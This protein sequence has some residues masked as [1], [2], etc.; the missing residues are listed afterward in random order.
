MTA[1]GGKDSRE[2]AQINTIGDHFRA[3]INVAGDESTLQAVREINVIEQQ[4]E[5]ITSL[6]T[7]YLKADSLEDK[8]PAVAKTKWLDTQAD[9]EHL[10]A[11]PRRRAERTDVAQVMDKLT[12]VAETAQAPKPEYDLISL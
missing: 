6:P 11:A 7:M 1:N 4:M 5:G 9:D 8:A 3:Q 12:Q 10:G 2:G